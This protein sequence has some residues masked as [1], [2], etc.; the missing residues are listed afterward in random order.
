MV[1][2]D[3]VVTPMNSSSTIGLLK[4]MKVD[5]SDLEEHQINI[6]RAELISIL[7]ASLIASNGLSSLLLKKPKQE[8]CV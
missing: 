3:L 7:S 2:D 6:S 1:S 8:T 5:F 4:K